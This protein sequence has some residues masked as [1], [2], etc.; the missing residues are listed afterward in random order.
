MTNP[1]ATSVKAIPSHACNRS[2]RRTSPQRDRNVEAPDVPLSVRDAT[3][4]PATRAA[5]GVS[6]RPLSIAPDPAVS[7]LAFSG[8]LASLADACLAA[9]E[10]R[11]E[12]EE[13]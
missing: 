3:T 9:E 11:A 13:H 5:V 6:P 2:A 7:E 8:R 4:F 10:K 1:L 12:A